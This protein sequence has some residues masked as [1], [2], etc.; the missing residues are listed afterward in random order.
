MVRKSIYILCMLSALSLASCVDLDLNPPSSASS[1][2][3]YSDADEI[4]ISINDF[5]R[6]YL[7]ALESDWWTDRRTDDWAQREEIYEFVVGNVTS[8]WSASE[9]FWINSYKGISRVNRVVEAIDALEQ[10]GQQEDA[11]GKH[12]AGREIPRRA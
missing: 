3:W 7:Y 12:K 1:E 8:E 6:E 4:T 5:Y 11:G 10:A 2:N 9:N